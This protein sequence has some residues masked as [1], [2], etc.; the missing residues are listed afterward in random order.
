MK[1]ASASRLQT[2]QQ[3]FDNSKVRMHLQ[4]PRILIDVT[5]TL[6]FHSPPIAIANTQVIENILINNLW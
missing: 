4:V 3:C 6:E 5:G 2:H 1:S